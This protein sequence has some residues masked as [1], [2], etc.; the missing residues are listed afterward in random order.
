MLYVNLQRLIRY[1]SSTIFLRKLQCHQSP[2]C[3]IW[4]SVQC[5]LV[6][7]GL[8]GQLQQRPT[9]FSQFTWTKK[10]SWKRETRVG[11]LILFRSVSVDAFFVFTT[12]VTLN[13]LKIGHLYNVEVEIDSY[14]RKSAREFVSFNTS[15]FFLR[16]FLIEQKGRSICATAD[17]S[18]NAFATGATES[19]AKISWDNFG[20]PPNGIEDVTL[21][22]I[23]V[24]AQTSK[25]MKIL[26]TEEELQ[27]SSLSLS[28]PLQTTA[29]L[30]NLFAGVTYSL[31]VSRTDSNNHSAP[32]ST[33][34]TS[35]PT[36]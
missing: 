24:R 23:A 10:N 4:P 3:I 16:W 9:P 11:I 20:E 12:D 5:R 8:N 27:A 25:L 36:R 31:E 18:Q 6:P 2:K 17:K 32:N 14:G 26:F 15:K 22:L 19:S 1:V 7:L 34:H 33:L 30:G 28:D 13:D 29:S 21:I 35:F